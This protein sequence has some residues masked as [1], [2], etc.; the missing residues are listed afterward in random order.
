MLTNAAALEITLPAAGTLKDYITPEQQE[1]VTKLK[2]SGDINGDDL[3]I[4]RHMI[5]AQVSSAD[6][7]YAEVDS[8][9]C[10]VLDLSEANIIG[11]GVYTFKYVPKP[12]EGPAYYLPG[13]EVEANTITYAMFCGSKVETLILPN[14]VTYIGCTHR[15][16]T[17][18]DHCIDGSN[19]KSVTL[20]AKLEHLAIYGTGLALRHRDEGPDYY[21]EVQQ[22]NLLDSPN[23]SEVAITPVNK[24]FRVYDGA[25]YN[26]TLDSLILCPTKL[27]SSHHFPSSIKKA[28][29]RA[30]ANAKFIGNARFT[31]LGKQS[32]INAYINGSISLITP[33]VT[34]FAFKD[35]SITG[36]VVLEEGCEQVGA[37]TFYN[38]A[39]KT[40]SSLPSTVTSIGD[41]SFAKSK[42]EGILEIHENVSKLGS[43]SFKY[44]NF[45]EIRISDVKTFGS[46]IEIR[47][48]WEPYS[49]TYYKEYNVY[50]IFANSNQLKKVV[51]G[52]RQEFIPEQCFKECRNL[53]ELELPLDGILLSIG[54]NAFDKTNIKRWVLPKGLSGFYGSISVNDDQKLFIPPF[55]TIDK[56]HDGSGYL[57]LYDNDLICHCDSI[58]VWDNFDSEFILPLCAMRTEKSPL[59]N[60]YVFVGKGEKQKY[61]DYLNWYNTYYAFKS[62]WS[63]IPEENWIEIDLL[64]YP[65]YRLPD[66]DGVSTISTN[67]SQEIARYDINGRLLNKPVQGINIVRYSDGTVKK[68]LVK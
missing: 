59:P 7:F 27:A 21:E 25:L 63:L 51:I 12:S 43:E 47:E 16:T 13:L 42:F 10:R 48:E 1:T 50:P 41:S 33:V 8:G 54:L 29:Y 31:S 67:F 65:N 35:A 15:G 66:S 57:T 28:G 55:M 34:D 22:Q 45:E 40:L 68:E 6:G 39:C 62:M 58:F 24:R 44:C 14:S 37:G 20:P 64:E 52:E 17:T 36:I 53:E 5:G 56:K 32:F 2:V 11:E 61:I 18:A 46:T 38:T 49:G 60:T 26:E 19:L 23:L 30:G 4:I 9:V 3:R